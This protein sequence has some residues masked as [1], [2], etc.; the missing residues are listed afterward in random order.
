[1]MQLRTEEFIILIL[2]RGLHGFL[3]KMVWTCII[4]KQE[5][6]ALKSAAMGSSDV[7]KDQLIFIVILHEQ[8]LDRLLGGIKIVVDII[9]RREI[10]MRV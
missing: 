7:T 8:R 2:K 4:A 9:A 6:I 5:I 10:K 1:M 3:V